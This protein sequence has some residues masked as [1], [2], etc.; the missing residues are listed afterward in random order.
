[1][2]FQ[3][4]LKN[5]SKVILFDGGMGSEV[6]KQGLQPGKLPDLLNIEEPEII[7]EIHKAYYE[8]GSDMCQTNTFGA[9]YLNLQQHKSEDRITEI[10]LKAIENIKKGKPLNTLIVG[11]IGPS[12]VFKPPIGK[13]NLELWQA[14]FKKQ[15]VVL[16]KGVDLWHIETISDI[17]E[18]KAAIRAIK[19]VSSKPIISSMTYKRTKRGFFTI[20]GDS[21]AKCIEI[22][23]DE[24]VDVIGSNCTLGSAD[25]VE[26]TKEISKFT[27]KPISIKPNAG[28][29]RL[30]QGNKTVYD[31][32]IQEFAN[33]IMNIIA[34]GAKIVGGCC[35]TS[36][37]TI[38]EIKKKLYKN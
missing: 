25:M 30:E 17:V 35:V 15:V 14:G 9:N 22:Q 23:S 6:I 24:G 38:Q 8:A 2:L 26:L 7:A 4:W 27:E 31:Q 32:T 12:G 1:M 29:P 34:E 18:M 33:D 5:P 3:E 10:N 16:E 19:E 13:A 20:M 21:V 36:P 11:D 37:Q 28:K